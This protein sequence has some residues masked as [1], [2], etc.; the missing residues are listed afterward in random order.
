MSLFHSSSFTVFVSAF[1][2]LGAILWLAYDLPL[3]PLAAAIFAGMLAVPFAL[4]GTLNLLFG[5]PAKR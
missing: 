2:G 5:G 3:L 1:I 4:I